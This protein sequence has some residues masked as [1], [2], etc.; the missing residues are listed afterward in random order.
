VIG[1]TDPAPVARLFM[2]MAHETALTER[3]LAAVDHR[4]RTSLIE[5]ATRPP[6]G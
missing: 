6:S 2:A 4:L 5:I 1:W 3:R